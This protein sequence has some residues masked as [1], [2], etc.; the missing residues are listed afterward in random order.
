MQLHW[1]DAVWPPQGKEWV[2]RELFGGNKGLGFVIGTLR[3]GRAKQ[4]KYQVH[5][6]PHAPVYL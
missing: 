2:A 3:A 6:V 1:A 5:F 4:L